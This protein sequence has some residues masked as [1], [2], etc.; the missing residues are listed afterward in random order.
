[1][2]VIVT[3]NA[4]GELSIP[5]TE[6]S[7]ELLLQGGQ[8]ERFPSPVRG[9]SWF[10]A[11]IVDSL[12]NTEIVRCTKRELDTF[13]VERA[14][15]N[16]SAHSF[17]SGSKVEL[18]VCSAVINGK[19]DNDVFEERLNAI[20]EENRV[21]N[22]QSRHDMEGALADVKNDY[23]TVNFV[24]TEG[25]ALA[26]EVAKNYVTYEAG[27]KRYL[28]LSGGVLVG[29]LE[30]APKTPSSP[31]LKV[32]GDVEFTGDVRGK[33]FR[34]TSDVRLK[35]N[36]ERCA[37]EDYAT[38]VT[39]VEPITYRWNVHGKTYVGVSAQQVKDILPEVVGEDKDG[40]L[41]VDY[42]GLV[43]ALICAVKELKFEVGNLK[44][45]LEETV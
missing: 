10:Y 6:D 29:A 38:R 16:T 3:N 30:I 13:Y 5:I 8:G 24:K 42:N 11:T 2:G 39:L 26:K 22:E 43:A 12:G 44:K 14:E 20:K 19:V 23:A 37:E 18:R 17:P 41:S 21:A 34:A 15:D 9:K 32:A 25:E 27:D 40:Y 35:E 1:M 45:K 4:W 28:L 7:K 33:T 36:V 31:S